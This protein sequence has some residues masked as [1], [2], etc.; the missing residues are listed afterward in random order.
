MNSFFFPSK[1]IFILF[2]FIK[3]RISPNG[4]YEPLR[5]VCIYSD[6]SLFIWEK[7][8]ISYHLD[9]GINLFKKHFSLLHHR[10]CIWDVVFLP[11]TKG[12]K[13]LSSGSFVTCSADNT[14]RFWG[15]NE[16]SKQ[17]SSSSSSVDNNNKELLHTIHLDVPEVDWNHSLNSSSVASVS[18]VK[19]SG[20]TI[21]YAVNNTT[22]DLTQYTNLSFGIPDAEFPDRSD[23]KYSPR[24]LAVHPLGSVLSVGDRLP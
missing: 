23:G 1:N 13:Y 10:A 7:Q 8:G 2:L 11:Q 17:P 24:S 15:T 18:V 14:V 6:R 12:S 3:L 21:I 19:A 9:S 4:K 5:V 20:E 16:K 22:P